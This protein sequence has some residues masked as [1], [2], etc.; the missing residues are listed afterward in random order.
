MD[1]ETLRKAASILGILTDNLREMPEDIQEEICDATE[2]Y[3]ASDELSAHKQKADL[4]GAVRLP[5]NAFKA[6]AGTEV[7]SD[8]I[9]LQKRSA[10]PEEL[11]DWV[12]LGETAD[13]LRVNSY[14]AENPEMI[15]GKIVEGNK[16]Y[17]RNDDTMCVPTP[18][19][20]LRQ[21]IHDAIKRLNAQISDVK[22]NEVFRFSDKQV[23]MTASEL[24]PFSF[25]KDN[26]GDIYIKGGES[27]LGKFD[28][29][30]VMDSKSKD[31]ER[32]TAFIDLRDTVREL[33]K[34]QAEDR[35]E[36]EIKAVQQKLSTQYD[37][38]YKKYGLLH[39]R[40]NLS[41]L[42]DDCSYNLLLTLE[43]EFDK[44]K[45]IAKSDIFTKRTV[46]PSKPIEHVD[47]TMSRKVRLTHICTRLWK[48]N[49][50]LSGRL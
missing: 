4:I 11:P 35:P 40:K 48:Q 39:S 23:T 10:P 36:N 29:S 43:K 41:V 5:N 19:A 49:S 33:L 9:F 30:K 26:K 42:R 6:N 32:M 15:L 3:E 45:L 21:Q 34:V 24:R 1:I 47:I 17:G 37:N 7:T 20:D 18:G 22:T 31:Y 14:F 8:I 50:G 2:K 13:G 16:L 46:R 28:V 25:F 12:H 44:D 38:F 27:K